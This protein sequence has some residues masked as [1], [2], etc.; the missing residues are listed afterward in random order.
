[1]RRVAACVVALLLLPVAA[2]G[3]SIVNWENPHVH[4]LD[5]TPDGTRLL[6]VNTADARL[7]VFDITLAPA[8]HLAPI[9]VGLEPVSV[10]ARS[11]T[12]AW[13]ANHV[14]DTVSIVD[15]AASHVV[16]TLTTNDEPADVVFAGVPPRAFVSCSQVNRILVFDPVNLTAPP[17]AV[18]IDAEDPRAM[19]VS[20]NGATVYVAAFESGNGSTILS[21]ENK[22]AGFF[23]PN[24]VSHPLGPYGGANPPPN[25]GEGFDPPLNPDNPPPPAVG[26][27]V[28][29]NGAGRWMDDNGGD[30]TDLV[31]GLNAALSGRP[32]GWDLP[33]HDVAVIDA[34]TLSTGY[35]NRLMNACMALA[36]NPAS[37]EVAV[38]GT[39]ALNQVRFEPHLNGRFLRVQLAIFSPGVNPRSIVDL[40]AHLTYAAPTVPQ[41]QRDLSIGDP[42]GIV[43]NAAGTRGYVSGMGSNNVVV[44]DAAGRRAGKQPTIEV[45]EGPTGLALDEPRAEQVRGVDLDH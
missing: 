39:E 38:V 30:W 22:A 9:P 5:V 44:I 27:I 12:E 11:N 15:L 7:E 2:Q 31:S 16:A 32:A 42:R 6:A 17:I 14:S 34:A 13:V 24:A 43:W 23:P 35:A 26:L 4:P 33:D 3:D 40:N 36:V 41:A 8:R 19:A 25:A 18:P 29:K 37:G 10:R 45:G 28:K 1:M 20:P 21:G